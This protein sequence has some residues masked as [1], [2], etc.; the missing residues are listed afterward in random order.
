MPLSFRGG[1]LVPN[2]SVAATGKAGVDDRQAKLIEQMY[3]GHALSGAV[4][5]GFKVRG[6]V[7][8]QP[9]DGDGRRRPRRGVAEGL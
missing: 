6:E 4:T 3:Q 2:A 1:K 7:S 5:A 9:V 8:P